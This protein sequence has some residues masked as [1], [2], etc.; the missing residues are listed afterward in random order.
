M[1]VHATIRILPQL[2]SPRGAGIIERFNN[3][4]DRRGPDECWPWLASTKAGYGRFKIA[5]YE[6]AIASRVALVMATGQEHLDLHAL[7]SCD[8]P[9]CCNP[10]HLRWGTPVD[11]A[12]DKIE[13]N[14]WK[15]GDQGGASNGAAKLS[16]EGL[17]RVVA[18][19][20]RGLNNKQIAEGLPIGHAMVSK[21]R[22]GHMWREQAAALGWT[23]VERYHSLKALVYPHPTPDSRT[24]DGEASYGLR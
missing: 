21:I 8:N 14:R 6:T 16:E 4:V 9:P 17:A 23:P 22:L 18:G 3:L 11:N 2:Q 20:K 7:H 15:G 13:R 12:T 5:S 10:A 1:A 24:T 19:L